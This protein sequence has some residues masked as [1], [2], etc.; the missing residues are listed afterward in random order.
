M[1]LGIFLI[2]AEYGCSCNFKRTKDCYPSP[3]LHAI[4]S[5]EEV[6]GDVTI[7]TS[8]TLTKAKEKKVVEEINIHKKVQELAS[9]IIEMKKQRRGVDRAIQKTENEL[10]KIYD[11][12]GVDCLEVDMGLLVR[13]KKEYGYEWLIEI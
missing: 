4:K 10:E 13:R 2:T 8:R 9:R 6:S 5:S 12:A 1:V 7:P 3:V 11:Q